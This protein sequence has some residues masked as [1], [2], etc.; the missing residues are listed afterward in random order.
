[1]TLPEPATAEPAC[2]V[3]GVPL[4][5]LAKGT[6]RH[7]APDDRAHDD[8]LRPFNE[9]DLS[10]LLSMATD[11]ERAQLHHQL[12]A[13]LGPEFAFV[14]DAAM[15][16]WPGAMLPDDET[17][18]ISLLVSTEQRRWRQ[19]RI[20]FIHQYHGQLFGERSATDVFDN[21]IDLAS[22]AQDVEQ[23]RAVLRNQLDQLAAL[24]AAAE[25]TYNQLTR[26]DYDDDYLGDV[27]ED[28]AAELDELGHRVRAAVRANREIAPPPSS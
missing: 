10:V 9:G 26:R 20:R 1:M 27:G 5:D 19:L 6:G 13:D 3:C 12:V 14:W 16:T 11:R 8:P 22:H 7:T 25:R 4:A 17:E 28:L 23:T 24:A 18:L 2:R 21:L 15:A